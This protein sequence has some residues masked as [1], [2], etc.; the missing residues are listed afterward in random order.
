MVILQKLNYLSFV[1]LLNTALD[2]AK[3]IECEIIQQKVLK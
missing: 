3:K 2:K 1:Y